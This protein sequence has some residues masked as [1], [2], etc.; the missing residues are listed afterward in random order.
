MT[1]PASG[2]PRRPRLGILSFSSGEFDARSFRIARSAI[3]AGYDVTLYTRW[4]AGQ[5]PVEE[6]EGYRLVRVP[7]DWRFILPW[8]RAGLR[9]KTQAA[10]AAAARAH[11]EGHGVVGSTDDPSDIPEARPR[12][13]R[14]P[15]SK[16]VVLFPL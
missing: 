6:R 1:T 4:H 5:R 11:A 16:R 2:S 12:R 10:M 14:D 3:A 8:R 13:V 15:L 9:V 7:F